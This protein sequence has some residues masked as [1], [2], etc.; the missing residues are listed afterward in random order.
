MLQAVIATMQSLE[1]WDDLRY[2]LAVAR[3]GKLAAAADELGVNHSTVFR[4]I[5][6]LEESMGARLFDRL[7]QGYEL[8]AIGEEMH[9]IASR[10]EDDVLSIGRQVVGADQ[11][12]HGM[13][14]F[15]TV[16]EV[17]RIVAPHLK[18][19][20][21]RYPCITLE[22]N[23]EQRVF[24]LSRRE[25]DVAIRPASRVDEPDVVGRVLSELAVGVYASSIYLEEHTRP[26][27]RSDLAR[28]HV[29]ISFDEARSHVGIH[30]WITEAAGPE[31][32]A[33][34]SNTI[35]GQV[36]A[37]K[38]GLGIAVLPRFV[39]DSEEELERLFSLK[40][41]TWTYKLWLLMHADLRQTARVRAFV[42]FIVEALQG[43]RALFE[44][45]RR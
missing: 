12:L 38:A 5:A 31:A 29:F 34:R 22:V 23:T 39:G 37:A 4:R 3:H 18:C 42:D 28:D 11:E 26:R 10:V 6:G 8:T 19:F 40:R 33:F 14:R 20:R 9:A 16:D 45:K 36:E 15:T 30:K 35:I 44:G 25:A 43:Q 13:V 2:F 32:I 41:D 17:L 1:N 21:D 24:S 27:R 7:P